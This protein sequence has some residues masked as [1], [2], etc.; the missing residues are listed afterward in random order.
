[1]NEQSVARYAER[2]T[3]YTK[4]G[5]TVIVIVFVLFSVFFFKCLK[6]GVLKDKGIVIAL[7]LL[8]LIAPVVYITS[9]LP[10]HL[11]IKQQTYEKYQGEFYIEDYYY[12]TRSGTY[13]LIKRS[14][15]KNSTRYR[16][17]SDLTEIKANT[18]YTGEFTIA[19]HSKV[20]LE[21]AVEEG[22]T[23]DGSVS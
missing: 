13:I 8:L 9:V 5:I 18:T 16:A 2:L 15:E 21:I 22:K 19:K 1:M 23:G 12:A 17:P 11:D 7:I 6:D 10:Y 20:L 3:S 4:I 14:G